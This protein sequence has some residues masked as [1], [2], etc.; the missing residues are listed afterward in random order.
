MNSPKK[1]P[2][3]QLKKMAKKAPRKLQRLMELEAIHR[4]LKALPVKKG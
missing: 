3:P 2:S 1:T 4:G